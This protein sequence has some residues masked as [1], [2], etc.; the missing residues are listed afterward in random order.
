MQNDV[1]KRHMKLH[2]EHVG[3]YE[4]ES[5][6]SCGTGLASSRTSLDKDYKC[7]SD[8]GSFSG[9]T[10]KASSINK[11]AIIKKLEMN[12]IEYKSKTE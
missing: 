11:E 3:K 9:T 12:G 1:L 2:E 7:E 4:N 8:F 5:L 10:Y 6:K